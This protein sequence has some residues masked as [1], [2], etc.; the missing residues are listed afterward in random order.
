[1]AYYKRTEFDPVKALEGKTRI[2]K[3]LIDLPQIIA[4][5]QS[6]KLWS[7]FL[8]VDSEDKKI[9]E[10]FRE[11]AEVNRLHEQIVT[12]EELCSLFGQVI[13]CVNKYK[14]SVPLISYADPYMLSRIGKFHV[15]EKVASVFMYIV[16]DMKSYPVLEEWTEK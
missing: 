12:I 10:F 15:Q 7:R 6:R 13:I 2:P 16:R 8:Q 1:M 9:L 14:S 3:S 5:K 11:F 4:E